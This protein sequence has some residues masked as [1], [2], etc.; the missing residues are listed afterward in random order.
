M[1]GVLSIP[2]G[3]SGRPGVND[4]WVFTVIYTSEGQCLETNPESLLLNSY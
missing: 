3:A 2:S 4:L 1:G